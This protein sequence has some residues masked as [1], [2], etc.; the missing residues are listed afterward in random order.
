MKKHTPD[1]TTPLLLLQEFEHLEQNSI[2]LLSKVS[3]LL[4]VF[5]SLSPIVSHT[6]QVPLTFQ[7]HV[8]P[9]D[10]DMLVSPIVFPVL[11]A[12]PSGSHIK[13]VAQD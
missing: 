13:I 11:P 7:I 4:Q 8:P 2:F 6:G 3:V 10:L 12:R 1:S 9:S 5:V